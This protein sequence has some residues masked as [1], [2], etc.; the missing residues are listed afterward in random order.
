M[1]FGNNNTARSA[2]THII[3][4]VRIAAKKPNMAHLLR[5]LS[6]IRSEDRYFKTSARIP[7]DMELILKQFTF[8]KACGM[9]LGA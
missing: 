2:H 8:L 1:L 6:M 3:A 9:S 5:L 7:R 4:M